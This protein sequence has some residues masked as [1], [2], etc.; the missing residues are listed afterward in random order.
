MLP[1]LADD[2]A[3]QTI[4]CV[5]NPEVTANADSLLNQYSNQVRE[6][7]SKSQSK[8]TRVLRLEIWRHWMQI[9]KCERWC[10]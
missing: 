4:A 9:E 7:A 3:V 1:I 8:Q 5:V 10:F 6:H 2:F